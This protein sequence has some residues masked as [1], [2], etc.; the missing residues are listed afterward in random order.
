MR[1]LTVL[2]TT[3]LALSGCTS[4]APDPPTTTPNPTG[5]MR[6]FTVPTNL[7]TIDDPA[8]QALI[9][10]T[11][12][13]GRNN[14]PFI[15]LEGSPEGQRR[16][17]LIFPKGSRGVTVDDTRAVVNE[18]HRL[19]GVEGRF[20][21]F[22]GSG[23]LALHPSGPCPPRGGATWQIQQEPTEQKITDQLPPTT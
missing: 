2:A 4:S 11:L 6:Y 3:L 9:S 19:Y 12:R 23:S 18:D 1:T 8:Y 21:K 10:G 15:A 22:G 13:F 7:W 14:C 20:V 16:H 5:Q 17:W